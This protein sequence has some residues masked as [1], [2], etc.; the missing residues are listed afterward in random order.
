MFS[1]DFRPTVCSTCI[2]H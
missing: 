2:C 1:N